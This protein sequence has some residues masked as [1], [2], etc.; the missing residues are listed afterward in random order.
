VS[1]VTKTGKELKCPECDAPVFYDP[2]DP[3][4]VTTGAMLQK[5]GGP[6]PTVVYLTCPNNHVR[7]Y[8]VG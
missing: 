8:D 6:K 3:M 7:R 4:H 1:D 5:P 2:T